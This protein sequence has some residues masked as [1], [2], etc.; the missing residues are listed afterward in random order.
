MVNIDPMLII[1]QLLPGQIYRLKPVEFDQIK[2]LKISPIVFVSN[3]SPAK[4]I[5]PEAK[6][7][8][9]FFYEGSYSELKD[10]VKIISC[11]ALTK[12]GQRIARLEL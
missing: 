2:D 7:S 3:R 8:D 5:C 1:N 12:F 9:A 10:G 4:L 11:L 6:A